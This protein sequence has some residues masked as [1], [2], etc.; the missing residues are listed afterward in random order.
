MN[1]DDRR[2]YSLAAGLGTMGVLHLATPEP[3]DAMVPKW[4][5]GRART[6]T[7]LSGFAELLGAAL[8]VSPRTR[9]IGGWWSAATI[10]AVYPANVQAALDGGMSFAPAPFDS[11]AVAWARLPFQIPMIWQAVKVARSAR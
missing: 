1:S 11:A 10:A 6:W 3:F 7:Y 8:V 4:M 9:R 2:A 5:P